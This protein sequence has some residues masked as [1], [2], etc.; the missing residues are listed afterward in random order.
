MKKFKLKAIAILLSS[1]MA[2]G[3]L[4][5]MHQNNSA[6][7]QNAQ[8]ANMQA[9]TSDAALTND[10]KA[11][12]SGAY[13]D[14]VNVSSRGGVIYLA[15]E[16]PSDT[17]Y[18]KVIVMAN[19][20][21]GVQ[22]VNV[23]ALTVKESEQPLYDTYITAK[24]KGLLIQKDMMGKDI[25]SWTLGVETKN[26][27]VYLSGTVKSEEERQKVKDAAKSVQGVTSVEDKTQV[28][29][30]GTDSDETSTMQ[31]Q[32][33]GNEHQSEDQGLKHNQEKGNMDSKDDN[34]ATQY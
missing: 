21:K 7:P 31:P 28:Q 3:A 24:V 26:G 25:P 12:V 11:A 17:D 1:G 18:E 13:A 14:K 34:N 23:D 2:G 10:V 9:Q 4:A 20:I 6:E 27:V 5:E 32:Q 29:A 22:D 16:L 8:P 33:S 30:A 15:G 19:S